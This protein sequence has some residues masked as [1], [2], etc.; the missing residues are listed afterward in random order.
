MEQPCGGGGIKLTVNAKHTAK[1]SKRVLCAAMWSGLVCGPPILHASTHAPRVAYGRSGGS[2]ALARAHIPLQ[3]HW[4]LRGRPSLACDGKMQA[5]ELG[6]GWH[7]DPRGC[8]PH[9]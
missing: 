4:T 6:A 8:K 2:C 7:E 9:A 3:M 5:L 1:G